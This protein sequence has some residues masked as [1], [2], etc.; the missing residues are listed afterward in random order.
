MESQP[1]LES[2]ELSQPKPYRR[3][4]WVTVLLSLYNP[5]LPFIYNGKLG[6]GIILTAMFMLLS[7]M[8]YVIAGSSFSGLIIYIIADIIIT[9]WMLIY[10]I[11]YTIK[12]NRLSYPRLRKVWGL[13]ALLIIS[14]LILS[15]SGEIFIKHSFVEAYKLPSGSMANTLIY[16]DYL[17]AEKGIDTGRLQRGEIIIFKFPGDTHQ[18]Y[19]KRIA[20]IG[21]DRIKID[22]KQLYVNGQLVP[23]PS[24]GQFCDTT[25]Y[26]PHSENGRWLS[27]KDST[28]YWETDGNR[29]NMP[30]MTVPLGQFFVLGDNRDNSADS[31]YWGCVDSKLVVGR[32]KFIHFSW[33]KEKFRIRWE[34]IGKR[35]E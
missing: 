28:S 23:L 18:N 8:S 2:T 3:K 4:I 34:R 15:V 17:I 1:D 26:Y 7:L 31:R 5:G 10:N 29:D 16:G 20:A 12:T 11:R 33:D 21:G 24:E 32:A 6:S 14:D 22:N 19:I 13:I 25:H 35:L 30:E 27:R 9:I